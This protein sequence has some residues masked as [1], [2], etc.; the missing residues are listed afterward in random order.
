MTKEAIKAFIELKQED[1]PFEVKDRAEALP[2]EGRD[3]ITIPGVRRCGK[4]SRMEIAV[5][6][7]LKRGVARQNILWIGFD[8]ERFAQM[9]DSDLDLILESYREL[10]PDT[11]LKD[12]IRRYKGTGA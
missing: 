3:I 4:S 7:L 1:M 5:N 10:H 11:E 8:D 9:K 2:L 6:A 12:V